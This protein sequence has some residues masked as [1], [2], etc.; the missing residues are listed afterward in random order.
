MP[1]T[2]QRITGLAALALLLAIFCGAFWLA[3]SSRPAIQSPVHQTSNPETSAEQNK[4]KPKESWV[5]R[6]VDDPIAG[7]TAVLTVLTGVLAWATLRLVRD[8]EDTAERQLRAYAFARVGGRRGIN[9]GRALGLRLEIINR[10]QTPAKNARLAGTIRIL[11][12]TLAA[13]YDFPVRPPIIMQ[14][15][16][17]PPNETPP[18]GGWVVA[19]APFTADEMREITSVNGARRAWAYGTLTYEDVFNIERHT[20]FCWFLDPASITYIVRATGNQIETWVWA[21]SDQHNDF[22]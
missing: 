4:E 18:P 1:T 12:V 21:V 3:D 5:Q 20:D 9:D 10:G 15:V 22:D 8:A 2:N 17:V 19:D 13:D 14:G 6:L 16:M 11:P 7:F